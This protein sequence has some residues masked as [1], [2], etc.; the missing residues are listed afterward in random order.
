M[1]RFLYVSKEKYYLNDVSL[2][3]ILWV[4]LYVAKAD[5]FVLACIVLLCVMPADW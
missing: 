5:D 2:L 1:L 3:P 4:M